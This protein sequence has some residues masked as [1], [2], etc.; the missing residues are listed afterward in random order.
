MNIKQKLSLILGLVLIYTV[1]NVY[2]VVAQGLNEKANLQTVQTLNTLA[3]KLSLFIHETQKERGASA[4]FLGSKGKK[5]T[6]ILPKQRKLT[7]GKLAIL[8][9]NI[10]S[11]DLESFSSSL[12]NEI[13]KVLSMSAQI[14]SIRKRVD[15]QSISV[16]DSVAFYTT[17]NKHILNVTSLTAKLASSPEL[18]KAL[19]A[20]S[21]FLKSKERAGIERAVMSATFAHDSFKKGFFAKWLNLV[22][23]QNSYA[24]AFTSIADKKILEFYHNA[25]KD[26][27]IR[28]VQEYRDVAL[29]KANEGHFGKDPVAWFQ[30][31]TKKINVLKK[32]DDEISKNNDLL[33]T[34]LQKDNKSH[35]F[36][37][38]GIDAVFSIV[39]IAFL[40]WIQISILKNVRSNKEQIEYI[41]QNRDLSKTIE[42]QGAKDELS[43]I[44]HSVNSMINSFSAT[45]QESTLVSRQ[46]ATQS[47]NLDEVVESLGH[48]VNSQQE[49]VTQMNMLME[50]VA[51]RL[52]EVEDASISTTEDL[53][54]T[55]Q[56]LDEFISKLQIS[57][58]NIEHDAQRQN[59]LSLK[60]GD[61]TEQARNITEILTI[62]NDIADQTNLLALNAAIEAA[63]AGEHGRGFAVV[64][65]EVRKL[66]ERTQKSL[67]EIKVS[68]NVIN[69][70]IDNMSEEAKLTS[71]EIEETS[72]LSVELINNVTNTKEQLT[73]TEDKSTHVMQKAT[74]IATKT[75]ELISFMKSIVDSSNENGKLSTKIN[76]VSDILAKSSNTLE[77]SLK[78][79]KI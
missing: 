55:K 76:E 9:T 62:I 6:D 37:E 77:K 26:D 14:P 35:A 21:N 33:I 23:E 22:S 63:R 27:S 53:D 13:S 3:G 18:V 39:L 56:A 57:V 4:G 64:A 38:I 36:W 52:D 45:I 17:L 28:A 15:A 31:I 16:K 19:S 34:Q 58:N 61:L 66:A 29:A 46:T 44:S 74:Y 47:Q 73:I 48:N 12:K 7:D 54:I 2:G 40:L 24:D 32:I 75:K 8:K 5:F 69:Q 42:T 10:S 25:I 50:D 67:D 70:N 11:I 65:D 60:V 20:Y 68:V 51:S 79:F 72:K 41:S 78:E 43:E 30:T 49:K 1:F 71:L 59:Q